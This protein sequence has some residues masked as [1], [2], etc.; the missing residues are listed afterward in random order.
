MPTIGMVQSSPV[1]HVILLTYIIIFSTGFGALAA[2]LV[3]SIRLKRPF[4]K[5]MAV[6]QGLFIASLALVAIYYYL[7]QVLE[8]VGPE[9]VLAETVFG[10]IGTVLNMGLYLGMW[11]IL[12]LGEFRRGIDNLN[13]YARIG[14]LVS[15]VIMGTRGIG[16]LLPTSFLHTITPSNLWQVF[17]Y[18]M[19]AATLS[20]FGLTLVKTDMTKQHD[21]YRLLVHGIG[22]CSLAF[23]PLSILELFLNRSTQNALYPLSLEYVFYLGINAVVLISSIRS[24]AKDPNTASAFGDIS[25]AAWSRFSLTPR[26]REMATL[27]AQG[28]SN[29][30]IAGHLG[31]SEATVR[32]HIYNLFQKVGAQSRIELLN[33]LHD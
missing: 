28:L 18:L 14:C 22:Y 12:G 26:E 2:L 20:L 7:M 31:I 13:L 6:V 1:K 30:E 29:K 23:V 25:E 9:Q 5:R 17:V 24:L 10:T 19:V 21:A 27:I 4:T 33:L 3:L 11:W 32:T 16:T 8:L 15:V